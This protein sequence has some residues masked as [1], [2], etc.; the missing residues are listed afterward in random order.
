[1][2]ITGPDID[3]N[4]LWV[5]KGAFM[6]FMGGDSDHYKLFYFNRKH[7]FAVFGV[8][9]ILDKIRVPSLWVFKGAFM[10]FMGGDSDH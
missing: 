3:I 8:E 6:T 1:V 10:T 7:F 2:F 9:M 5:F 4:G